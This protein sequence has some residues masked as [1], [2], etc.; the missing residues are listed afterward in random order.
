MP[1]S[2]DYP[3]IRMSYVAEIGGIMSEYLGTDRAR[4]T[5]YRNLYKQA[6]VNYF[7]EAFESGFVEGGG[8]LPYPSEDSGYIQDAMQR[9]FG[10]IDGLFEK[11]RDEF[12]KPG[13]PYED[14]IRDR[15]NG[16]ARQLD[17]VYSQGLARGSR[18][19]SVQ[20]MGNDGNES[21]DTC[22]RLKGKWMRLHDVID[23]GLMV[24]PGNENYICKGFECQ[25]Y[26][27]D[28]NG[29]IYTA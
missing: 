29:K 22:G 28:R 24:E 11:L 3:G 17:G 8:D 7:V 20:F 21:C 25:H 2:A 13:A 6:V 5:R 14:E 9:E 12:K 23:Q 4:V 1:I 18:N 26:W 10:F 27:I 15:S 19:V 16:Y